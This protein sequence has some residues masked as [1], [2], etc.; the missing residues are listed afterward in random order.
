MT[1]WVDP[2]FT[3][4]KSSIFIDTDYNYK[5]SHNIIQVILEFFICVR[6][7]KY[8]H[9]DYFQNVKSVLPGLYFETEIR[10]TNRDTWV[11]STP[12]CH[13]YRKKIRHPGVTY[14]WVSKPTPRRKMWNTP[15]IPLLQ[16]RPLVYQINNLI[17]FPVLNRN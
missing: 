17:Q 14:T 12:R 7:S 16:L 13:E 8:P 1:P 3:Q 6:I 9:C 11:F 4:N 15:Y 5:W 2:G 10:F